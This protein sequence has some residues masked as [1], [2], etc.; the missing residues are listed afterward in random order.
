[1]V[2]RRILLIGTQGQ[3]GWELLRCAQSLGMVFSVDKLSDVF[4]TDYIDLAS[5]DSIRAVVKRIKPTL[6]LN[7]AAYTAVDKAEQD[8]ELAY[9]INGTAPGILAELAKSLGAWLV[10]YSTDYV[11]DGQ[12]QQPYQEDDPVNPMSVYGA[13]KLAGD[14]AIQAVGGQYLIFRTAW[15]YGRRGQNFLLTMQRLA[16]EREELRIVNDQ[17]GTPTWSKMI[18]EATV[19]ILAQLQSPLLKS[20]PEELSGIYHLTGGGQTTW[21]EFTKAIVAHL[22]LDKPPRILPITTAEYPTPA[23]R[24]A[25]SVLANAKIA[26]TFGITLPA[27]D[28][29]LELCL[30]THL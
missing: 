4:A 25:Y 28:K 14:Q 16:K 15:V 27:W 3:V 11:Y 6:I 13:S 9:K 29:A 1:M 20:S 30:M 7:A 21:Y 2:N 18:A 5:P 19:Q 8:S 23:K 26:N 22:D 10:H 24:P 17:K 12:K